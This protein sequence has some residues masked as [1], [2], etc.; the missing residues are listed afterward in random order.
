MISDAPSELPSEEPWELGLSSLALD[1]RK[2]CLAQSLIRLLR[3]LLLLGLE[4]D[5]RE[6]GVFF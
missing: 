4:A 5:S 6:Y 3:E 1:I 2:L